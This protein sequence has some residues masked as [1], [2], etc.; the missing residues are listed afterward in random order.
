MARQFFQEQLDQLM[1]DT[2]ALG[3]RVEEALAQALQAVTTNDLWLME[4]VVANDRKINAMVQIL[5]ERCLT[6]IARQQPMAGDLREISVVLSLLPELE[7]MAD[8]AA[9]CCKIGQRMNMEPGF[10]PLPEMAGSFPGAIPEMGNRVLQLLHHGLDA[11]AWRNAVYAEQICREDD[12]VD[13][14]YKRLFHETIE[15]ARTQ[16][17]YSDEAIHLLTLAHN[18][19]RIGDR[20]TNLAEQVIFLQSGQVVDLNK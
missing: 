7:R 6:L 9:T 13:H 20:V 15:I 14:I 1:A 5:H 8:H 16:P 10:V 18:L 17:E 11:L 19:E 12:E 2:L 3:S 4:Q